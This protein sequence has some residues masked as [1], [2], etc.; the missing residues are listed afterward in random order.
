[1]GFVGLQVDQV[2]GATVGDGL[3]QFAIKVAELTDP[4]IEKVLVTD[5]PSRL[6]I[7]V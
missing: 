7:C 2:G 3:H 1:M 6:G 5:G 4:V